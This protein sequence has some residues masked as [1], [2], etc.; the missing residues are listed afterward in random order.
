[1]S[2]KEYT[3]Q[4]RVAALEKWTELHPE[5]HR[6]E[7]DALRI[8]DIDRMRRMEELNNVRSR[9]VD[10]EWFEKTH[11]SLDVRVRYL[12]E[13]KSRISGGHDLFRYL[14]QAALFGL[15]WLMRHLLWR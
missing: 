2:K 15:G 11:T 14:W 12:E 10:K 5:T 4:E 9:F 8:A 3:L 7:A 6:L 1:M 13:S